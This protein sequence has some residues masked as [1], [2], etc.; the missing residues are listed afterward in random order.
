MII[1]VDWLTGYDHFCWFR[2]FLLIDYDMFLLIDYD[3]FLLIGWLIMASF[4]WLVDWLWHVFGCWIIDY[5]KLLLIGWF[6]ITSY[7]WLVD[8]LSQVF[9]HWLIE[10]DIFIN[11][12]IIIMIVFVDF[13]GEKCSLLNVNCLSILLFTSSIWSQLSGKTSW[14]QTEQE[15]NIIQQSR[16]NSTQLPRTFA[17]IIVRPCLPSAVLRHSDLSCM[18][19]PVEHT[20]LC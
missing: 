17:F 7:C 13:M 9:V 15:H 19:D 3:M 16:L 18:S 4:C 12:L 6:I 5:D 2:K 10:H 1:F 14:K 8:W 20:H 11:W